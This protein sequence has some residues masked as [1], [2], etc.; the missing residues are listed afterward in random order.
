MTPQVQAF[1]D[2]RSKTVSYIVH[3]GRGSACVVI[4][5]VLDFDPSSGHTNEATVEKLSGFVRE[6]DLT[7]EWILETHIHH[8][9][10]SGAAALKHRVGG[11]IGIG[12]HCR[13]VVEVIRRAYNLQ[14]GIGD[15]A[16]DSLFRDD[17]IFS[18]GGTEI[19][20]L[21]TPGHTADSVSYLIGDA[22]F[23]GDALFMPDFGTG[24]C[25]FH[26]GDARALYRSIRRLLALPDR[27]RMFVCHD[28]CPGGRPVAWETT[29]A[30]QRTEN[31]HVR[32]GVDEDS[33]VALR[34][35]RDK[36][37]GAPL[38][39]LPSLQVNIRGGR[40]PAAED[41]GMIYLK[42]PVNIAGNAI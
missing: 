6:Q 20:V 40:L 39:L 24:R 5:P 30:A 23:V 32:D 16:F 21:Y 2:E 31:V 11:R 19:R 41:N 10:L 8:D 22:V 13:E 34:T 3:S 37:L 4:D 28:Y 14:P 1:Y 29:V 15:G 18:F 36:G 25:N 9:H 12:E 33:F 17:E 38:L 26:G 7:V 27:T 42:L 35:E